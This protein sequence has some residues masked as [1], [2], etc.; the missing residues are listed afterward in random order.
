MRARILL[1]AVSAGAALLA[2]CGG[3]DSSKPK[4]LTHAELARQADAA[5]TQA[6]KRVRALETPTALSGLRDYA[7]SVQSI[8]EDLEKQLSGLTPP[9]KDKAKVDAY[10]AALSRSNATAG[11][12]AEA[13]GKGDHAAV[14][15]LS[16]RLAE[17]DVGVL[18]AR[19]GLAQCATAVTLTST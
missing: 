15:S 6:S 1:A 11:Q 9:A 19:A 2:G 16:D 7:A 5:C 10:R 13:A 12:L 17:S 4:A 14:R 18:A 3:G 8:G